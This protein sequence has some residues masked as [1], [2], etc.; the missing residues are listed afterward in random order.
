[1][2]SAEAGAAK[3]AHNVVARKRLIA[4]SAAWLRRHFIEF[5]PCRCSFCP[6]DAWSYAEQAPTQTIFSDQSPKVLDV[7]VI[8][9]LSYNIARIRIDQRW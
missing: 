7:I 6:K 3:K 2:G 9:A 5:L 8:I 4:S 1:M